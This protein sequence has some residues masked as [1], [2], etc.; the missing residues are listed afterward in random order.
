[1]AKPRLSK[2][3]L[4]LMEALW[5]RGELSIREIQESLPA[6]GRPAYTTV[7]TTI[8]RL[9]EK[10]AVRRSKK[11]GNAHVFEATVSRED[12]KGRLIDE[13]LSLFGGRTQPVMAHL[14]ETGKLTIEDIR[15]AEKLLEYKAKDKK[16]N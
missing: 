9:E 16:G 8:Y 10:L 5:N 11:I 4:K 14:V 6:K 12:V 13:L 15:A 3:E 1:L 7:Q 2:L